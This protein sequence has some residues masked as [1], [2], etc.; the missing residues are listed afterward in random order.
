M[1]RKSFSLFIAILFIFI[2]CSYGQ[3]G[4]KVIR[5]TTKSKEAL[6]YYKKALY[7]LEQEYEKETIENFEKAVKAD[8]EFVMALAYYAICLNSPENR[9]MIEEAKK[10]FDKV[11]EGEQMFA[12]AMEARINNDMLKERE[13]WEE[14][15]AKYPDD[16]TVLF[17]LVVSYYLGKDFEKAIETGTKV[18]SK[19][20]KIYGIYN[21]VGYSYLQIGKF[22]EAISWLKKYA[23]LTPENANPW[24]SLGD[25]YRSAGKYK[26][27]RECYQKALKIKPDFTPSIMHLGD[28]EHELGYYEEAVP[29]YLDGLKSLLPEKEISESRYQVVDSL[30]RLR[31]VNNYLYMGEVDKAEKAITE[32]EAAI[33]SLKTRGVEKVHTILQRNSIIGNIAGHYLAA[34]IALKKEDIQKAKN[35]AFLVQKLEKEYN[36]FNREKSQ[37]VN[38]IR[39]KIALAE[40]DLASAEKFALA[41][42]NAFPEEGRSFILSNIYALGNARKICVEPLNLLAEIRRKQNRI[43]DE[44]NILKK[45][46]ELIPHQPELHFRLGEIYFQQNKKDKAAKAFKEFL[47]FCK[48]F[49]CAKE[50]INKAEKFLK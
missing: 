5:I 25:A 13:I 12:L 3:E 41:A 31:L 11:T 28:I 21:F 18:V 26:E 47:T 7:A 29:Y 44:I 40:K 24:D 48:D 37:I 6:K 14:L 50:N 35:E 22:N 45:S 34:E 49:R 38:L 43:D 15:S 33:D 36:F 9:K 46:L 23:E 19:D 32:E 27:A 42:V 16:T 10:Y 30:Y 4:E 1:F 20:A 17:R 8:P 39:A 2:V